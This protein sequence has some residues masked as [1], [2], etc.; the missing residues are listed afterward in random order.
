MVNLYQKLLENG[1]SDFYPYHMPG[2]K[3]KPI[4]EVL[5][6][7]C[8]IDITEIDGFD[9]LH[10]AEGI[11][12]DLQKRAAEVYGAEESFYLVNGSTSGILSAISAVASRGDTILIGRNCHKSVYHGAYLNGLKL[13]YLFP[14]SMKDVGFSCGI[15]VEQVREFLEESARTGNDI[16]AVLIVSPTYEGMVSDIRAI[17]EVVHSYGIP[18]IVD[19]A[20]GAHLGFH[21][22]WPKSACT[23]GADIV[24]QSLHKTL[25]S[26]TQTAL[27]HVNGDLVDRERL[28]RFLCVYQTSSPSYVFMAGMAEA[29]EFMAQNG[30]IQ[31]DKFAGLWGQMLLRLED[32]RVLKIYPGTDIGKLVISVGN[33]S[34]SGQKL[35]DILLNRYHLQMEMSGGNYVLAMFTLTDEKDAYDRLTDA[36]LELDKELEP[37][38]QSVGG[39][40]TKDMHNIQLKKAL[41]FW[42]AWDKPRKVLELKKCKGYIAGEFINL[43]PPG[44]PMLVPGEV[45]NEEILEIIEEYM[46]QGLPV[47]GVKYQEGKVCLE[48]IHG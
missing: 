43:Y 12:H 5:K 2:H 20:H 8:D 13:K 37:C 14:E 48:V 39:S 34:M 31:M 11:L 30:R 46:R 19:E 26:L 45:L 15:K 23:E 21:E 41:E 25:P 36:L 7:V 4:T 29:I 33:S 3:R 32:C 44:I 6:R 40:L 47:Q 9:N 17:A 16:K 1:K 38:A 42:E 10:H 18:L 24:I 35:Y 22:L 28:R 27:L